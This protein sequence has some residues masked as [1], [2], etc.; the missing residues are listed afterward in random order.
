MAACETKPGDR[1]RFSGFPLPGRASHLGII[2]F[3][4][5]SP[6]CV[7]KRGVQ[8]DERWLRVGR[9]PRGCGRLVLSAKERA[10]DETITEWVRCWRQFLYEKTKA[11]VQGQVVLT[12][13]EWLDPSLVCCF[14]FVYVSWKSQLLLDTLVAGPAGHLRSLHKLKSQSLRKTGGR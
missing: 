9:G 7:T 5:H 12:N 8:P 10:S 14:G 3:L 6:F 4:T 13:L 2:P 11:E 1:R